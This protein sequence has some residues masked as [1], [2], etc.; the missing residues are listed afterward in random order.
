MGAT[1]S[2][3]LYACRAQ[4]E[5]PTTVAIKLLRGG[6]FCFRARTKYALF[7]RLHG[8]VDRVFQPERKHGFRRKNNLLVAREGAACRTAARAYKAAN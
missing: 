7:L 5:R 6:P 4:R 8:D 1:F 2:A 3:G